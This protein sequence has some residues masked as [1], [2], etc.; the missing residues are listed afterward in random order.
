MIERDFQRICRKDWLY[1]FPSS[2]YVKIPDSIRVEESEGSSNELKV[3]DKSKS[4]GNNKSYRG[5]KFRFIPFKPYDVY[6][7]LEGKFLALEYKYSNNFRAISLKHFHQNDSLLE[8]R[9]NMGMSYYVIGIESKKGKE[10]Y[11]K[12]FYN[13]GK[14][15]MAFFLNPNLPLLW[16]EDSNILDNDKSVKVEELFE[17]SDF[18]I[19]R[20]KGKE[21]S[22]IHWRFDL[23]W[24]W[25][26][27]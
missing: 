27:Y 8:V 10:K 26:Y 1:Y 16:A 24:D 9:E 7:L 23:F 13:N 11:R 3:L 18:V 21:S 4:K 25:F 17:F 14:F 20:N 6:V 12:D 22:R 19:G 15:H 5:S 2:H